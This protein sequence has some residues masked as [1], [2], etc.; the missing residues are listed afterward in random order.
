MQNITESKDEF[1][2]KIDFDKVGRRIQHI[3]KLRKITQAELSAICGCTSNHLSAVENGTNKPSLEM[4]MKISIALDK[5]VDYFL[6]DAPHAYPKYLIET[7]ISEKLNQ[8]NTKMLQ[9]VNNILE[10]MLEYQEYA[11]KENEK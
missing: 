5:S 2:D 1:K 9:V 7:Q 4:L 8:C 3:R 10:S 6:M 11:D